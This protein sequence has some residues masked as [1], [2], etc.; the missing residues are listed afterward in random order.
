MLQAG[1][2]RNNSGDVGLWRRPASDEE[3][4]VRGMRSRRSRSELVMT[5]GDVFD[6][7]PRKDKRRQRRL[8][9]CAALVVATLVGACAVAAVA[10]SRAIA[11]IIALADVTHASAFDRCAWR[12]PR[13]VA[14]LTPFKAG[15]RSLTSALGELKLRTERYAIR[16]LP[17]WRPGQSATVMRRQRKSL[18]RLVEKSIKTAGRGVLKGA[19]PRPQDDPDVAVVAVAR[20]PRDALAAAYAELNRDEGPAGPPSV[21]ECALDPRCARAFGLARL[22]SA[23][24]L[25]LCGGDE[26]CLPD[27][28]G[29]ASRAA[30]DRALLAL[31]NSVLITIPAERLDVDGYATLETL[32]PTY[33]RGLR[34]A[35]PPRPPFQ[36][37]DRSQ[38]AAARALRRLC[39]ADQQIFDAAALIYERRAK[40]CEAAA[41]EYEHAVELRHARLALNRRRERQG[42]AE[43][44]TL[45]PL[46]E[47][48]RPERP[49][50]APTVG[51]VQ[52]LARRAPFAEG[53]VRGADDGPSR[54]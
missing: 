26:A 46:A 6:R 8:R 32:L 4:V 37:K 23:Q 5:R 17:V 39:D 34:A 16:E 7:R 22:C 25:A 48:R 2:R 44:A 43:A 54:T 41:R 31:N 19:G 3:E 28:E 50:R 52:R 47:R 51:A 38:G 13:A 18:K 53:P 27:A 11:P 49:T 24:T 14:V 10:Q 35:A 40:E 1:H 15:G 36:R 9:T 12:D 33:F 20:N 21:D 45:Q 42:L 29:R 30:V